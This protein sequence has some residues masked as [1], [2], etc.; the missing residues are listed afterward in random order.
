MEEREVLL[1]IQA[2]GHAARVA[3]VDSLS[4]EE[5][6]FQAPH[7]AP[8]W[9]I[10]HLAMA[11]LARRLGLSYGEPEQKRPGDKPGRGLKV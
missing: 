11:K 1:E 4:G 9:E 2:I 6:V 3:A 7:D 5:V 10:E 8:R